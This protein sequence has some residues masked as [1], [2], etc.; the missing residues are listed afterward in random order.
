MKLALVRKEVRE[1][2]LVLSLV[3]VLD[4]ITLL[5]ML[6]REA[7]KGGRFSGLVQF[8]QVLGVV[9]ALVVANRV[10]VREYAGRTQLFLE[11]LPIGR[12]RVWATKWLLGWS[13]LAALTLAAWVAAWMR[14]LR[15]EVISTHDALLVLLSVG[16]FM[17][18]VWGF[19]S[20]AGMLGRHRYTAWIALLC[21]IGMAIQRGKLAFAE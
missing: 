9:S 1:H 5:G 2:W 18:V 14:A 19:A 7:D 3:L 4:A 8:L 10:F 16:S 12:A 6:I 20:M 17:L 11:V 15:T 13:Y 21:L